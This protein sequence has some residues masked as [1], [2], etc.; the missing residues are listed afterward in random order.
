MGIGYKNKF[1]SQEP[2]LEPVID[3]DE[4]V[5]GNSPSNVEQSTKFWKPTKGQ[6]NNT[7]FSRKT[8]KDRI[9]S[10][11]PNTY[12]SSPSTGGSPQLSLN[13]RECTTFDDR[14]SSEA[15]NFICK[16]ANRAAIKKSIEGFDSPVDKSANVDWSYITL[17]SKNLRTSST[18]RYLPIK[19][20]RSEDKIS[21]RNRQKIHVAKIQNPRPGISKRDKYYQKPEKA[22]YGLERNSDNPSDFSECYK[23]TVKPTQNLELDRNKI[24]QLNT[25]FVSACN[26]PNK[27]SFKQNISKEVVSLLKQK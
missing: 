10:I 21:Y 25:R 1:Q 17:R 9:S 16:P 23:N 2:D 11:D 12:N 14:I 4:Y 20:F 8:W 13:I 7:F 6:E 26:T 5:F 19:A 15:S 27:T 18:K 22:L 3:F 24:N